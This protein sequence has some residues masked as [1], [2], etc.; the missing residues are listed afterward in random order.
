MRSAPELAAGVAGLPS[1]TSAFAATQAAWR[2]HAND[3]VTSPALVEPLRAAGRRRLDASK[4]PFALL[5]HDW[6]EL[7][8]DHPKGKRDLVQLTHKTDVGYE[9]T[10]AL[11]VSAEDGS[12]SAPMEVHLKTA[13]GVLGA[14]RR[15]PKD[16]A[17][18]EQ[19]LPTMKASRTWGLSK[20]LV[21]VIDR[22]ADSVD[23]YPWWHAAGFRFTIRG[24][25]RSVRRR[26]SPIS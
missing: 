26:G 23:H 1:T 21:H 10:A 24:D 13:A 3:R 8:F 6:S 16:L 9:A 14:R 25:D 18:L 4:S 20:P 12:P 15:A 5:V 7:S 22:E 19:V 17:H 2:F 11:L